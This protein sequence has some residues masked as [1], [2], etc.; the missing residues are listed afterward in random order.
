VDPTPDQPE[1]ETT[2]DDCDRN[3]DQDKTESCEIFHGNLLSADPIVSGQ[4]EGKMSA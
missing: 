4:P 1:H 2:S 3:A